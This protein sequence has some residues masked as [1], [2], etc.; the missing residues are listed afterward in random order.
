MPYLGVPVSEMRLINPAKETGEINGFSTMTVDGNQNNVYVLILEESGRDAVENAL[1][2][3]NANPAVEIA[4]P[5]FLYKI[6]TMPNDPMFNAQYALKKINAEQAWSITTGDKNIVVGVIDTGIEGTHPDLIDNLWIN[7]NPDPYKN[8]IHGFNFTDSVGGIPTDIDGHGTHVAGIVGAVGNNSVGISGIN[9]NVSL[10]WLG[11]DAGPG[12][13]SISSAIEALNYANNHNIPIT[14]NSYGGSGRSEIFKQAIANYNGLFVASAGN[15]WADN[16]LRPSY[17][18]NYALPNVISVASTHN[19]DGLSGF[20]NFG[21]SVHIAAPGSDI[22]STDLNGAYTR[23]NGTSMSAPYVA[24]V[25]ALILSLN[26]NY[27]PEQVKDILVATARQTNNLTDFGILDAYVALQFGHGDL[28]NVTYNFNDGISQPVSVKIAPGGRLIALA[29]PL[30]DGYA[31]SGWH[32]YD[33]EIFNFATVITEDMTLYAQWVEAISGMWITAFPDAVFRRAVQQVLLEQDGRRR[34]D[35]CMIDDAEKSALAAIGSLDIGDMPIY[36]VTGLEYLTGLTWLELTRTRVTELDLS[37]QT[38]LEV[39]WGVQMGFLERIDVTQNTKLK[40][41]HLHYGRRLTEID[42]SNNTELELLSLSGNRLTE[43]DVS[44]NNK[45]GGFLFG[46]FIY[47]GLGVSENQLTTLDLSQNTNLMVLTATMNNLTE[48]DLS[49]NTALEVLHVGYNQ[50]TELD[51]S[52]NTGLE[53]LVVSHNNLTRLDITNNTNLTLLGSSHNALTELELSNNVNLQWINCSDNYLERLDVSNLNDLQGLDSRF[54]RLE[55]LIITNA[56][57]TGVFDGIP[58]T[59]FFNGSALEGFISGLDA[60]YNR[61]TSLDVSTNIGL[62]RLNVRNNQM[63]SVDSVIGWRTIPGLVLDDGLTWPFTFI[64]E[65]QHQPPFIQVA[66]IID[67]PTTAIAG[68]PLQLTG[69]IMPR[70]AT[71]AG[72][73]IWWEL[74]DAGT[75]GATLEWGSSILYTNAPG[76]VNIRAEVPAGRGYIRDFRKFFQITVLPATMRT[77][78]ATV[79]GDGTLMA[80]TGY[81]EPGSP[82]TLTLNTRTGYRLDGIAVTGV[83]IEQGTVTYNLS[84][85][86]ITF[87][88]PSGAGALDVTVTPDWYDLGTIPTYGLVI[89]ASERPT[90]CNGEPTIA[91]VVRLLEWL[92]PIRRPNVNIN[93]PASVV[94]FGPGDPDRTEP[95]IADVVRLLEWLDPVR[96]PDVILGP[97]PQS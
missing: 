92:D 2:I 47:P 45:L 11:A 20:S 73:M 60:S 19:E 78:N 22:L 80:A 4:E 38:A 14:N 64:F 51:V 40:E 67:V 70:D 34:T 30:R 6:N 87:Y 66:D 54:N 84:A 3:L 76:V 59:Y 17:P 89:P 39:L 77:W 1:A 26:P 16:D 7:P 90:N 79:S 57:L 37:A 56:P 28:L 46:A 72:R 71:Y 36:D 74:W 23:K 93:H 96:R 42:V 58:D 63:D 27:I 8:D 85:R 62:P 69:T 83:G 43:L 97:L 52:K 91:D 86:T 53:E 94:A 41:L 24:G 33:G 31:F 18:A 32:T 50:L 15:D 9:W 68:I 81:A 5:D 82:V 49:S 65:P 13:I 25:A 95:T 55:E 88:M 12:F 61:L 35:A 75:T 21:S 44:N 10:A 29:T 48:L